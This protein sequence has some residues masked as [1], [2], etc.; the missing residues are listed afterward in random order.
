MV[1]KCETGGYSIT[2]L[3]AILFA[4]KLT[5]FQFLSRKSIR[6]IFYQGKN[7]TT[8]SHEQTGVKGYATGFEGLIEYINQFLP[9]NE[10]IGKALRKDV[11]MYPELAIRELVANALVHQDFSMQGAGPMIEIFEGRIEI[12]NPG[13]PLIEKERFIDHPPI[14]RNEALAS[15]MRRIGVCEERGSGFDKVVSQ[16]EFYQLPAPEIDIYDNHTRVTLFSHISFAEM[17]KEDR[18]RACY[19]HACLKRVNREYVT[20]SSLRERFD[21]EEKNSSMISRLIKQTLESGLI[22]LADETTSD[23]YKKY[24]PFWA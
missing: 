2:N 11:P 23:K 24:L 4:K 13:N 18:I 9:K 3:G 21:I 20:N 7:K 8:P 15:F 6:V 14:S 1:S 19:L 22:K 10:V 16:T 5:D 17:S 12:T